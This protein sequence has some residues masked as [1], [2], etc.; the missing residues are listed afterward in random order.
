MSEIRHAQKKYNIDRDQII[1]TGHSMG[2]SGAIGAMQRYPSTFKAAI[3]SSGAWPPNEIS[4]IN[5][6]VYVYHG[7]KNSAVPVQLAQNLKSGATKIR[8]PINVE[9]MQGR[10]HGI[11]DLIYSDENIWDKVLK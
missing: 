5:R 9:I 1:I 11:G 4:K 7:D 2:G 3:S 6:R 10:G 8:A